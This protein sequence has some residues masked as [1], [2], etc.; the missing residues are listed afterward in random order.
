MPGFNNPSDIGRFDELGDGGFKGFGG[1]G[2]SPAGPI[3]PGPAG[4]AYAAGFLPAPGGSAG[5]FDWSPASRLRRRLAGMAPMRQLGGQPGMG[6]A[7][8]GAFGGGG[9][10]G[11]S[12]GMS[13]EGAAPGAMGVQAAG[14]GGGSF[15]PL[16]FMRSY[17]GGARAPAAGNPSG[18]PGGDWEGSF[19]RLYQQLI[20]AG[21][22]AGAFNPNGSSGIL[23]GLERRGLSDWRAGQRRAE[24]SADLD[25]H[26][27]DPLGRNYARMGAEREGGNSL[28]D[29]LGNAR[30]QSMLQNQGWLQSLLGGAPASQT[31]RRDPKD[32]T[33]IG[34]GGASA[35]F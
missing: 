3:G 29:L 33:T 8:A 25:S 31:F 10:Y 1:G 14:G 28:I 35:T 17:R 5:A 30:L 34:I 21:I 18:E 20:G 9:S 16:D 32:Q 2:G 27:E 11:A 13:S 26:G 12:P 7:Q 19:Q 22:G 4:G 23:E 6:G 24:L 15:S